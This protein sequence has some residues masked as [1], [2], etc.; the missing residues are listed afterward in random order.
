MLSVEL[1][2][3]H[4]NRLNST[5]TWAA[6]R[7]REFRGAPRSFHIH[8][9]TA[10]LHVWL[11]GFGS[12]P[13]LQA[14]RVLALALPAVMPLP[15]EV[16]TL[17]Q[18]AAGSLRSA[19]SSSTRRRIRKKPHIYWPLGHP[20]VNKPRMTIAQQLPARAGVLASPTRSLGA[21]V[22]SAGP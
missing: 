14:L 2:P 8:M 12:M 17:N 18:G 9:P 22:A 13:R 6:T 19:A 5:S 11:R 15:C 16:H 20:W 7:A 4:Y 21:A 10:V 1:K 3:Q